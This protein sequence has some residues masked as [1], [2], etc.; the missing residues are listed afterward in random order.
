MDS[1]RGDTHPDMQRFLGFAYC[2]PG[3]DMP[4]NIETPNSVESQAGKP[5]SNPAVSPASCLYRRKKIAI[6]AP[7]TG[8][9]VIEKHPVHATHPVIVQILDQWDAEP[10]PGSVYRRRER[11]KNVMDFPGIKLSVRLQP[12]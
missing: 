10:D 7:Q 9:S 4:K 12:P 1:F 2:D 5:A 3:F 8:F 6:D 11:W